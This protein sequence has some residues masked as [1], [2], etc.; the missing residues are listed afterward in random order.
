MRELDC[1][2]EI[3][4]ELIGHL[5]TIEKQIENPKAKW[6][7]KPGHQQLEYKVTLAEESKVCLTIF[8]RQSTQIYQNFSCGIR[9][10]KF[11]LARY[12][13]HHPGPHKNLP[14]HDYEVIPS[15]TCHIHEASE[16]ALRAGK[17]IGT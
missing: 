7:N 10:D 16:L 6:I 5:K 17:K 3:T 11:I 4:D 14:G 13:G 15:H 9:L 2:I 12:N 1:E 8:K